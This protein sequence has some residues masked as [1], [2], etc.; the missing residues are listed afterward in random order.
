MAVSSAVNRENQ[1]KKTK[2]FTNMFGSEIQLTRAEFAKRW[3]DK[4]FD[5][6]DLFM[7]SE[8]QETFI[9]MLH[10][11]YDLACKKWDSK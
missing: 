3:Q 5:L 11:T 7:G 4:L 2:P 6:G 1:M 10:Y 9:S 8:H